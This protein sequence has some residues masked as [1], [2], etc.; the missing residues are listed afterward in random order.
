MYFYTDTNSKSDVV[1]FCIHV[2]CNIAI[3]FLKLHLFKKLKEIINFTDKPN[4]VYYV[5][6]YVAFYVFVT[7]RRYWGLYAGV[8]CLVLSVPSHPI[9]T[10][11]C[12][13]ED[14]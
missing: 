6:R 7:H 11:Y 2:L 1:A 12:C 3:Y 5:H 9:I 4:H 13:L 10:H 8:L 14:W